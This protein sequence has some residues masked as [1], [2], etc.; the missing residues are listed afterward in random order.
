VKRLRRVLKYNNVWLLV[1]DSHGI[2]V[3]CAAAGGHMTHH[4]LIGGIRVYALADV[5]RHRTLIVPQ[6]AATGIEKRLLERIGWKIKW[7]PARMEDLPDYLA[8]SGVGRSRRNIRFMRFPWWERI[9]M[10]VIWILPIFVVGALI[11][12]PLLG[13]QAALNFGLGVGLS[14]TLLFL[15]L[16]V[17]KFSS[18]T[19]RKV[20]LRRFVFLAWSLVTAVGISLA[21]SIQTGFLLDWPPFVLAAG[22]LCA[23]VVLSIDFEGTTPWYGS[24]VARNKNPVDIALSEERCT[25]T[26]QCVLVCPRDVFRMD[27][28]RRKVMITAPGQCIQCGACIVQCP[29]DALY[30]KFAD[31]KVILPD[32]I[33]T[34]RLN[35]AGERSIVVGREYPGGD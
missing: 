7:G 26:A 29:E 6:L 34:T 30:F 35:L 2:N 12:L 19:E 23:F 8:G 28:H 10:A 22:C 9:E 14:I 24:V 21:Y 18:A 33:R 13:I 15:F 16:P 4:E 1:I 3:W 20:G 25:G 17:I 27:G 32:V 5:V 31:G 11:Y